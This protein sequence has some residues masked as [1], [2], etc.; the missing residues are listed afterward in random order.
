MRASPSPS[1]WRTETSSLPDGIRQLPG[2][3]EIG[4]CEQQKKGG[5]NHQN[6]K[7]LPALSKVIPV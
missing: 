3:E 7:N 1:T 2:E 4:Y 6:Q 5:E